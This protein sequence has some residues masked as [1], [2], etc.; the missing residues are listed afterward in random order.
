MFFESNTYAANVCLHDHHLKIIYIER[1]IFYSD[2]IAIAI[3]SAKRNVDDDNVSIE[4]RRAE[5][6]ALMERSKCYDLWTCEN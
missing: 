1:I 3:M 2:C 6:R 5:L 4:T